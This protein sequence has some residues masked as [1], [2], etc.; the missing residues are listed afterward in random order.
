MLSLV[1]KYAFENHSPRGSNNEK[2]QMKT[3]LVLGEAV[4]HGCITVEKEAAVA[5]VQPLS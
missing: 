4:K 3:F 1:W 5:A 2:E